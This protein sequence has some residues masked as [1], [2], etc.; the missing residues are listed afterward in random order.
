MFPLPATSCNRCSSLAGCFLAERRLQGLQI[1]PLESGRGWKT[2]GCFLVRAEAVNAVIVL[3]VSN[4][5]TLALL[6]CHQA[7]RAS[8]YLNRASPMLI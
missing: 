1:V 3:P 5:A 7:I 8:E 4:L 2:A 6:A